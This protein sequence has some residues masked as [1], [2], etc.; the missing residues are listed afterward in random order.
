MFRVLVQIH[1]VCLPR[2][3]EEDDISQQ[4]S[5]IHVHVSDYGTFFLNCQDLNCIFLK[6]IFHL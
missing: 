3:C 5:L 4:V 6:I 1:Y 2:L